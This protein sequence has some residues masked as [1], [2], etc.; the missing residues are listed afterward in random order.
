MVD[1]EISAITLTMNRSRAEDRRL[2]MGVS[3]EGYRAF[4]AIRLWCRPIKL[5]RYVRNWS[6]S[7]PGA[8]VCREWIL[9]DKTR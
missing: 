6:S 9:Q 1:G 7:L 5:A 3:V 8:L 4:G 2:A